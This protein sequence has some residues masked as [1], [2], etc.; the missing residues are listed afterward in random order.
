MKRA[1]CLGLFVALG[2]ASAPAADP[3]GAEKRIVGYF[4]E[5]S[6]YQRNYHVA[7]IP[8]EK[9]T[10]INYA[11][12]KISEVGECALFDSY[13]AIDKFYTGDKWDPGFLRGNFHQL[14]ILKQNHPNLKTLISVGGWTLSGRFSDVALTDVSRGKFARSCVAF[15]VKYGFDGIDVDWEY[16]VG[17]GLESNKTRPED[18]PNYTL[19]L[20]E[21]RKQLDEQGKTDKKKYLLT[22][23][24]PAGPKTY[25]NV[26]LDKIHAHLDWI[27]LMTYD[28]H[29]SWS[30][31]TNFNAPLFAS[32]ADPTEDEA[33]RKHFNMDSAVKAYLKA[34]VPADKLVLGVPFYGRGWGGVKNI[35]NGLYQPHA[36][37]PPPGTW[38]AGVFDYKD[39][40]AKYLGK[41]ARHWHDDAKVPWLFDEKAGI[42]ISYD[43]PESLRLKAEYVNRTKLGGVMFW[44]LSADDRE[45]SLLNVLH[46][47]LRGKK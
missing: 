18:K 11:F 17:G 39:I 23:A 26:E 31:L 7:N 41:M 43:D 9:L 25:A 35:N 14:Q 5:W 36:P 2:I 40:A 47:V 6:V 33:I 28:F 4:P 1:L 46:G 29:G 13:A 45:A 24:A 8:A 42:M 19:L 37:N 10:H 32:A 3:V 44:E 16:P 34:G 20:A 21:L 30:T 15:M 27:N 22:I 38:E 12:A